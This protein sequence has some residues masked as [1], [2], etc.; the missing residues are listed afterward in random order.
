MKYLISVTIPDDAMP[1]PQSQLAVTVGELDSAA[2]ERQFSYAA[3]WTFGG[4]LTAKNRTIFDSWWRAAF[5]QSPELAV[6]GHGLLW[7]YYLDPQTHSFVHFSEAVPHYS[8]PCTP[9]EAPFVP[10]VQSMAVSHLIRML[11]DRDCPVLL[12]GSTGSGKTA[13]LLQLLK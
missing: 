5:V 8:P 6:P 2:L 10:T 3:V 11:I 7:D 4:F 13:T 9:R 1:S 12:N